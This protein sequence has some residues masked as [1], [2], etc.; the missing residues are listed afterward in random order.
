MATTQR[1]QRFVRF[2]NDVF[3]TLG[4]GYRENVYKKSFLVH[5]RENQI[6]YSDEVPVPIMYRGV[7]VAEGY[8]DVL[9]NADEDNT[10]PIPIEF[11]ALVKPPGMSE[12]DQLLNYMTCLQPQPIQ[13]IVI[14]FPQRNSIG[15]FRRNVD[16]IV[17][18]KNLGLYNE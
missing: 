3:H 1:L 4:T 6:S 17:I 11:K 10:L 8:I 14:N 15:K 13:G 12:H 9:I 5:L 16:V 2:C 18:D 7:T